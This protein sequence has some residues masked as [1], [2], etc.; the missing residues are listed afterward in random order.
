MRVT[1]AREQGPPSVRIPGDRDTGKGTDPGEKMIIHGELPFFSLP[2][3]NGV[4]E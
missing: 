3:R 4:A 1:E 2:F